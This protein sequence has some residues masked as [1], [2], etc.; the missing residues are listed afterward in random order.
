MSVRT[1]AAA[2]TLVRELDAIIA[3]GRV[4]AVFQPVVELHSGRVVGYESLARGPKGSR[5]ER[6]EFMFE[7]ARRAGRVADLDWLCRDAAAAGA[8]EAGL[9]SP[10][11]LFV[12]VEPAALHKPVPQALRQTWLRARDR[13]R[14]VLEVTE[15]SL[16]SSPTELL[17]S[18]ESARE[19]GWGVAL[20]DVGADP[21][22]PAL[23]P[24]LS[25]DVVKLDLRRLRRQPRA[26]RAEIVHALAAECERTGATL[27]AEGI[28]TQ[29]HL[30][31]ARAAG[32][33]LGQGWLLGRLAPMP[34]Q[35]PEPGPRVRIR[36][37]ASEL[38]LRF[39]PF[40]LL[41]RRRP[42]TR[43][44]KAVLSEL[45]RSLET[46]AATS[47][48]AP[49]VLSAFQKEPYLTP[50]TR[51]RYAELARRSAC[52][53]ALAAG[54]G[55]VPAAGVRGAPLFANDPLSR[56]WVVVVV[57][58]H[59]AAALAARDLGDEGPEAGRRFD[60]VITYD[61]ELVLEV[62]RPLMARVVAS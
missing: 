18:V 62:A 49:V 17:W 48:G 59:F 43:G 6:P 39:T 26:A 3:S 30:A 24:F 4:R 12:N 37:R 50:A 61:R 22:S 52:V 45:G 25:P 53:A 20:D 10:F 15:G 38:P 31:T 58:A 51:K 60:Y 5:L 36:E 11:T 33:R 13:L 29:E 35:L 44:D 47:S 56:E 46:Q 34:R 28:E 54:I 8:L 16:T 23:L 40:D 42:V 9:S 57:G 14:I 55:H 2:P 7:A 1:A 19:L 32:A 27:L 21:R 41:A